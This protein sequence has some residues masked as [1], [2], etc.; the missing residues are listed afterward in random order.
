[1]RDGNARQPRLYRRF[2]CLRRPGLRRLGKPGGKLSAGKLRGEAH[3]NFTIARRAFNAGLM[4]PRGAGA[5]QGAEAF[6]HWSIAA[7]RAASSA[8]VSAV[9]NSSRSPSST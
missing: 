5:H 8:E 6:A 9:V 7:S 1:M 2:K 4:Q 3:Q